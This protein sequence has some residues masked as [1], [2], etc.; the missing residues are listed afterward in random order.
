M[1]DWNLAWQE[2]LARPDGPLAMRF[3]LQPLMATIFAVR[4]GLRD[5]RMQRPAYFWALFTDPVHRTELLRSGWKSIGKIFVLAA[6]LDV[7]YQ[8]IV[9]HA[10]RPLETLVVSTLLAIV[11]YM[12]FRGP[13]NRI[14][15]IVHG[16]FPPSPDERHARRR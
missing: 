15:K 10:L 16:G 3:Y 5:A 1:V 9:L 8:L 11:P 7:I 12:T 4:D 2:I 6:V 13:V 14:A